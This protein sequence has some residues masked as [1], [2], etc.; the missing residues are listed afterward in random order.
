MAKLSEFHGFLELDGG[1]HGRRAT[2]PHGHE[3]AHI[4]ARRPPRLASS[5]A[6]ARTRKPCA[7][8][9]SPGSQEPRASG[10]ALRYTASSAWARLRLR[11][12]EVTWG[13]RGR[14]PP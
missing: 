4:E 3:L 11:A 7:A 5:L 10:G 1:A 2:R 14:V 9:L 12:R 6:S 8:T 13:W